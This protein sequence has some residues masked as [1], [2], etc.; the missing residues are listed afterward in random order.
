MTQQNNIDHIIGLEINGNGNEALIKFKVNINH[1]PLM[2]KIIRSPTAN[3]QLASASGI[4]DKLRKLNKSR[5][6]NLPE[7][8]SHNGV[9]FYWVNN[10]QAS[11][12][13][14]IRPEACIACCEYFVQAISPANP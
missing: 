11:P 14:F 12:M 8:A 1:Y 4:G 6:C 3:C 7:K 5:Y 13:Q 2:F 9:L 10:F